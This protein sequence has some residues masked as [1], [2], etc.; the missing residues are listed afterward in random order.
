MFIDSRNDLYK[1]KYFTDW[2]S[3]YGE[4]LHLTCSSLFSED[5][6]QKELELSIMDDEEMT[7]D[8]E[9]DDEGRVFEDDLDTM[10]EKNSDF[11]IPRLGK[12][13]LKK[14]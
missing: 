8:E 5:S 3:I 7:G 2:L 6:W 14:I 10:L 1:R 4:T 11:E 12:G 13:K 9:S